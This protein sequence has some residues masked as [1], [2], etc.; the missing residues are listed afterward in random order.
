MKSQLLVL[1]AETEEIIRRSGYSLPKVESPKGKSAE[2]DGDEEFPEIA[3]GLQRV[4]LSHGLCHY[5]T[6]LY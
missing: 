3:R 4:S 1:K 2:D 5:V 6:L